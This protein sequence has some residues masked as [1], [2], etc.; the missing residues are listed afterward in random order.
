MKREENGKNK[1]NEKSKYLKLKTYRK[2][3]VRNEWRKTQDQSEKSKEKCN[4]E[5]ENRN[6]LST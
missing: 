5:D 2:H 1:M 3:D 4:K 6:S